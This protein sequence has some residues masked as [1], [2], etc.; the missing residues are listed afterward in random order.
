MATT[1]SPQQLK[2]AERWIILLISATVAVTLVATL[3]ASGRSLFTNLASIPWSAV[4][5]LV[6]ATIISNLLRGWRYQIAADALHLHV[7]P[8]RM[9]YYYTVGYALIP[10]PGKVGIAIRMWLLRHYHNLPYRRT[11]PLLIMDLITDAIANFALASVALLIAGNAKLTGVGIALAL[12][13]AAGLFGTIIAPQLLG[14]CVK[15]LYWLTGKRKPRLFARLLQLIN[16]MSQVFG[17]RV[18]LT[19][20]LLSLAAWAILAA[21]V[22]HLVT[23]FGQQPLTVA[24]GALALTLSN[25]GGFVTMMPAGVGGAEV[26]M[27]GIFSLFGIPLGIA[28]LATALVRIVTLWFTVLV[29]LALLPIALRNAPQPAGGRIDIRV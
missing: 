1:F 19:C 29:G 25:I 6:V 28:V 8:L 20:T 4:V 18:F 2:K 15:L 14:S 22:A 3:I 11:A 27:A 26:T 17:G 9:L 5:L 13:L 7:P 10:T 12:A 16:T 23:G 21:A 24:G